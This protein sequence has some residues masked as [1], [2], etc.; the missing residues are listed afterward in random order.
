MASFLS[1]RKHLWL[2]VLYPVVGLAF[3]ACEATVTTARFVMEWPGVDRAIPFVPWMVAPYV[4]WYG[5][6]AFGFLWLGWRDGPEF[7]RY[8]LFVYL[9]MGTACVVYLLFPNGQILRPPLASLSPGWDTE[10]L[11]WVYTHDSPNNVNPSIHVIATMALWFALGRDP[12]FARRGAQLFLAVVC[13]TV[14]ASTVLVKQHS[15][16]DVLGGLVVSG[17][18][19]GVL[20]APARGFSFHKRTM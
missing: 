9:G 7:V 1:R 14:M 17:V 18:L 8:T 19:F 20:Y 5:L 6:V 2:L 12:S 16:L 4:L 10:L 13:L 11:R 3:F 15:I